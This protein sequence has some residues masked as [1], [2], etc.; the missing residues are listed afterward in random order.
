MSQI[1]AFPSRVRLPVSVPARE[2]QPVCDGPEWPVCPW[3]DAVT[4]YDIR[5]IDLFYRLMHDQ[6]EG[7]RETDIARDVF[8]IPVWFQSQRAR[9][10]VR[11][12]M[13]RAR[14]LA[15]NVFPLLG[16]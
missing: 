13:Q 6:Y 16:W 3:S 12:H 4:A 14:W 1:I 9:A 8:G 15:E 5:H 11:S 2:R 7:A 10:I